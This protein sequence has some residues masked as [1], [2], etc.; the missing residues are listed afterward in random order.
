[1]ICLCC[2]EAVDDNIFDTKLIMRHAILQACLSVI[3]CRLKK[4]TLQESA[5]LGEAYQYNGLIYEALEAHF[6]WPTRSSLP[7]SAVSSE[8]IPPFKSTCNP[9][10]AK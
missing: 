10:L 5:M 7:A 8:S 1:M 6:F 4:K 2:K 9:S 3:S